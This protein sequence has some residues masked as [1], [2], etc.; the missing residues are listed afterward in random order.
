MI[1]VTD[2]GAVGDGVTD[3]TAAVQAA[4]DSAGRGDT[5]LLPAGRTFVQTRVLTVANAGVTVTGG[6]PCWP[7]RSRTRR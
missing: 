3:D 4:L 5:V 7:P 1:S 6:G 2:M